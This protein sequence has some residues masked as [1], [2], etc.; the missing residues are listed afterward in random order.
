MAKECDSDMALMKFTMQKGN[1]LFDVIY[2]N[3]I[4]L[5]PGDAVRGGSAA[6]LLCGPSTQ[7]DAKG[8]VWFNHIGIE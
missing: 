6:I 7:M 1:E 4:F 8:I 5:P 2:G 3:D